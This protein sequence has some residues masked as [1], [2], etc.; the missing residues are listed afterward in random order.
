MLDIRFIRENPDEVKKTLKDRGMEADVDELLK[1][2]RLL[3]RR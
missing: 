1:L 2:D 3:Q